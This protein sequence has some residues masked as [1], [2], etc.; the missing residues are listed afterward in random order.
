MSRATPTRYPVTI[1]GETATVGTAAELAVALDVLQGQH[2]RAVLEQLAPHL[3]EIIGGPPGLYNTLKSLDGADQIF[4]VDSLGPSLEGC[5]RTAGHLRDI[6]A[7]LSAVEVEERLLDTLGP[8]GLRR[9]IVT[10]GELAEILEWVYGDCDRRALELLGSE[11]LRGLLR[12]GHDL[13]LVLQSLDEGGQADLLERLGWERTVGLVHNG[14]DLASLLR[15][16]PAASSKQLLG[17]YTPVQLVALV[18]N[19]R[20]WEYLCRRLEPAEAAY[21]YAMLGVERHA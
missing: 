4:L 3:A 12:S 21:L 20:D 8:E 18:G 7:M 1:D 5:V 15:A 14:R 11:Y 16:L 9:L 17:H 2:D 6:L 10:P 19:T 13:S